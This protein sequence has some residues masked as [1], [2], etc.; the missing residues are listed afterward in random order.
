[1][2][3]GQ[4]ILAYAAQLEELTYLSEADLKAI[5]DITARLRGL[6]HCHYMQNYHL[7]PIEVSSDDFSEDPGKWG[8]IGKTR[9]VHIVGDGKLRVSFGCSKL[10]RDI[11]TDVCP[12]C[13]E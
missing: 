10:L 2:N 3:H 8:A 9:R 5:Y 12:V 13:Q 7:G 1:V 6:I 4:A 11:L